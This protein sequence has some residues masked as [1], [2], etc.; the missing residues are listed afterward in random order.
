MNVLGLCEVHSGLLSRAP[1]LGR[2]VF[3]ED[4]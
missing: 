3:I 4:G 1:Q 2:A